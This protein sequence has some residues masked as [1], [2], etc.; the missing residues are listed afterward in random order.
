MIEMEEIVGED[1]A[2]VAGGVYGTMNSM[3]EFLD[4]IARDGGI[5]PAPLD[6]NGPI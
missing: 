3:R 6:P 4:R 2:E 1:I 5:Y